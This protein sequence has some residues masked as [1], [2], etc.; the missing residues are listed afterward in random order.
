M[1]V[2]DEGVI[3]DQ[4]MPPDT[5]MVPNRLRSDPELETQINER[6]SFKTFLGLS[7]DQPSPYHSTFC[8]LN[9]RFSKDTSHF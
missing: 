6:F 3:G 9:S 2:P 5:A 7:F 1:A 8:R 4:K